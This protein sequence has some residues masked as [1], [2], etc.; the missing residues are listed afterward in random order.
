MRPKTSTRPPTDIW[1]RTASRDGQLSTREAPAQ[2]TASTSEAE[3]HAAEE[4]AREIQAFIEPYQSVVTDRTLS[5]T[6]K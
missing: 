4:V 5:K 2:P 1:S 6:V 3:T